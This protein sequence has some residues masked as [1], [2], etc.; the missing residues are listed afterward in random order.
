MNPASAGTGIPLAQRSS[1]LIV[2][3]HLAGVPEEPVA[4]R[5][6]DGI[7]RDP[8]GRRRLVMSRETRRHLTRFV[9]DSSSDGIF[10]VLSCQDFRFAAREVHNPTTGATSI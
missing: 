6:A 2:P 3:A 4:E 10:V 9:K 1:G 8:D 7:A 5:T